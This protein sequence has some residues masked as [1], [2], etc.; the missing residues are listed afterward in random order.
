MKDRCKADVRHWIHQVREEK[1]PTAEYL[2]SWA[3]NADRR[4][5]S[6]DE[7]EDNGTKEQSY[8]YEDPRN[9][10]TPKDKA[11]I[12]GHLAR[13]QG[14]TGGYDRRSDDDNKRRR[15]DYR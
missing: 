15:R 9:R 8:A 4:Y 3:N 14:S 11:K 6:F 2:C 12:Q 13:G 5:K 7:L 1:E 10:F